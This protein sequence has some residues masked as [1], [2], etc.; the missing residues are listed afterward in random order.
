M[1]RYAQSSA[2]QRSGSV[3]RPL[4]TPFAFGERD[5]S[6]PKPVE[7]TILSSLIKGQTGISGN[8]GRSDAGR[9]P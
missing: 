6:L 7:G 9:W 3:N 1:P 4:R 5:L 2:I 8:G